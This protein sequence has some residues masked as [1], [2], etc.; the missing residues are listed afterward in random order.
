MPNQ[1]ADTEKRTEYVCKKLLVYEPPLIEEDSVVPA[2]IGAEDIDE[3]VFVFVSVEVNYFGVGVADDD[4]FFSVE[5]TF[6][7]RLEVFDVGIV[8]HLIPATNEGMLVAEGRL[9]FLV[10]FG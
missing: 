6:A 5:S 1:S 10:L 4:G 9:F 2:R 7:T 3:E 8:L